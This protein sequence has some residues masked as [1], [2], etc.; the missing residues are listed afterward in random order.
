MAWA[1][2]LLSAFFCPTT[3]AWTAT[4]TTASHFPELELIATLPVEGS[5][6]LDLSGL[7]LRRGTLHAVSDKDDKAIYRIQLDKGL[8]MARLEKAFP[9]TL[10]AESKDQRCDW[11]ALAPAPDGRWLLASETQH[12]VLVLPA[13]GGTGTWLTGNLQ[14]AARSHGLLQV[15]NAGLEG[16]AVAPDGTLYLAAERQGRGLIAWHPKRDPLF[17]PF[18]TSIAILSPPRIPDFSELQWCEGRLFAVYRNAEL[19]V[20]LEKKDGTWREKRGWSYRSTVTLPQWRYIADTFGMVE[21][22][23]ITAGRIYLCAD[24]NRSGRSAA[25]ADRRGLLYI[26]KRPP[27]L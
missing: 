4:K 24:N 9:I 26:F 21:G 16:L 23:A 2:T 7:A 5:A 13:Q 15:A 14:P 25:P 6:N 22:M 1:V 12:R 10:P 27:D 11:E 3:L 20:E 19:L 18:S 17:Y 8:T